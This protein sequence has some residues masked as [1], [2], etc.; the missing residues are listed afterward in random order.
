[1]AQYR[2]RWIDVVLSRYFSSSR[3]GG[4]CGVCGRNGAYQTKNGFSPAALRVAVRHAVG[5]PAAAVVP[6][7][8]LAGLEAH[9]TLLLEEAGQRRHPLDVRDD[10]FAQREPLGRPA[11]LAARLRRVVRRDLVLVRVQAR[12]HRSQRRAAQGRGHVTP[13]EE[14]TLAGQLVDARRADGRMAQK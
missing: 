2:A 13:W 9:V 8:P 14:Q 4:L 10:L 1:M 5:E 3:L 12:H 6:H 7:P 11:A